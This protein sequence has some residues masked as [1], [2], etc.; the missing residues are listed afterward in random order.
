M[1]DDLYWYEMGK[2]AALVGQVV[3]VPVVG[4]KQRTEPRIRF[5]PDVDEAFR[6]RIIKKTGYQELKE[7]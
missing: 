2:P 7:K 3:R 5:L 4:N 6:R 1:N